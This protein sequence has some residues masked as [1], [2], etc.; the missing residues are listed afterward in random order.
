[1]RTVM[2]L[3]GWMSKL[4]DNYSTPSEIY[5]PLDEEFHFTLDPCPLGG[6]GGRTRSWEGEI[7]FCNPPY[8][9]I[10]PWV[11]KA[12]HHWKKKEATT[13]LLIPARTDQNWF[14]DYIWGYAED[15]RFIKGRVPFIKKGCLKA[16]AGY[17]EPIMIVIFEVK[18]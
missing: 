11:K 3:G 8:S 14:H 1:M 17:R 6:S 15:I 4:S 16:V 5:N 7:V 2:G 12:W 18:E 9:D 10:T 13:V